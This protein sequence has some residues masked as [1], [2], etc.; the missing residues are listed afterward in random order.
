[1]ITVGALFTSCANFDEPTPRTFGDGPSIEIS[2]P[3]IADESFTF[4]V[5][6]AA[7]T[8]YYSYAVVESDEVEEID[9]EALLKDQ[10][11][12][13]TSNVLKA[14]VKPTYTETMSE[15][16]EPFCEPNTSYVIYA[17]AGDANGVPGKVNAVKVRTTDQVSPQYSTEASSSKENMYILPFSENIYRGEGKVTA[18]YFVEWADD[19]FVDVAEEDIKVEI[20]GNDAIFTIN[21]VPA[22]CY[23]LISFETGAFV[24][25]AGNKCNSMESGLNESMTGFKGCYFQM[26]SD[27]MPI[28][29]DNLTSPEAGTISDWQQPIVLTF[30]NSIFE[31]E[32]T[33]SDIKVIYKG[34]SKTTT[35]NVTEWTVGENTLSF[36]LP[37][38]PLSGDVISFVIG[39][40]IITDVYG[41]GNAESQLNSVYKYDLTK[42][43]LVGVGTFSYSIWWEGDDPEQALYVNGDDPTQYKLTNWGGD[44]DFIF[45]VAEDG[46]ITWEPFKCGYDE[47]YESYIFAYDL[48]SVGAPVGSYYDSETGTFNFEIYYLLPDIGAV[49]D[50]SFESPET[51]VLNPAN[52][53]AS[54]GAKISGKKSIK[55]KK[56]KGMLKTL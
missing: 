36:N 34:A 19:P 41:N 48:A 4:T 39:E 33:E 11:E 8:N 9:A 15:G 29:E 20:D 22:N 21:N 52:A 3:V 40:G 1:M 56:N 24:D 30:E 6:P 13:L 10:I 47:D 55:V 53:K 37:E 46:T 2:D 38:E 25:N 23:V 5:T 17:V 12:C 51:F 50:K 28:T 31:N 32:F 27:A 44:V 49:Y 43:N 16:G 45:N 42:W 7:G 18:Q 54:K 26:E 35:F 14:S